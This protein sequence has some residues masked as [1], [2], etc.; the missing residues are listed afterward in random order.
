M[1]PPSDLLEVR[2]T[3]LEILE[4]SDRLDRCETKVKFF[5]PDSTDRPFYIMI[6]ELLVPMVQGFWG[7]EL[8]WVGLE[9]HC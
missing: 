2:Y 6:P 7:Q 5:C 1:C 9:F 4:A 8:G 3:V